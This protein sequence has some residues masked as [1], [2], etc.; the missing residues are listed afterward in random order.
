MLHTVSSDELKADLPALLARA[1]AGERIIVTCPDGRP[2]ACLGGVPKGVPI[3]GRG[4]GMISVN[5]NVPIDAHLEDFAE[6]MG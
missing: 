4:I 2:V 1:E 6:Y 5:E 3:P